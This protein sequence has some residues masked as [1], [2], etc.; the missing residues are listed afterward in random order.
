M[1][2]SEKTLNIIF[3]TLHQVIIQLTN[4]SSVFWAVFLL[5]QDVVMSK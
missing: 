3:H 2:E 5:C 4:K 1:V